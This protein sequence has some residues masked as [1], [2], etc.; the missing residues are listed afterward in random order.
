MIISQQKKWEE[1]LEILKNEKKLFL[2][3]CAD[4]ATT[5]KTGGEPEIQQ[6]KA[7]LE[8]AGKTV[9]GW[10]VSDVPCVAAAVK[11][12]FALHRQEVKA[13]DAV[14]SFACGE[15]VQ[16]VKENAH[17]AIPVY[18]GTNTLFYGCLGSDNNFYEHCTMCGD[19]ILPETGGICPI[20][21]CAKGLLN[22]PCGGMEKGKCEVDRTQDC[23]W[24]L[25]YEELKKRG[26]LEVF[27]KFKPAKDYSLMN[28]P[29]KRL[30]TAV[31][32]E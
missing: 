1:I 4:C 5:C 20:T 7:K 16:S 11:K 14:I 3:G 31:A 17:L 32:K 25:I 23:A 12:D 8:E 24:I 6:V 2:V 29:R 22:G 28:H 10:V 27:K 15:C 9:T 21:R 13:A 18:P 26:K 30:M 19:C